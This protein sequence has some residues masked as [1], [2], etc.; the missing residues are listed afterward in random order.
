PPH[1]S[2][3]SG[4]AVILARDVFSPT[5]PQQAAGIRIEPPPSLP[6][7]IGC[8]PVATATAAPPLDPPAVCARVHGLRAGGCKPPSVV[9]RI[10]NSGVVVLPSSIP[11][12]FW[13][14]TVTSASAG[15]YQFS[16]DLEPRVVRMSLV[17]VRSFS[18]YAIPNNGRFAVSAGVIFSS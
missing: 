3:F 13:S 9:G 1:P 15:A 10:P 7:A 4:A 8:K 18:E 2:A 14:R 6:C 11:P 5:N 17:Q 12:A 16:N